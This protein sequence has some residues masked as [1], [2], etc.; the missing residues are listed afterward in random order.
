MQ[1]NNKQKKSYLKMGRE[2]EQKFFQRSR[3]N[4]QQLHEKV[5]DINNRQGNVHTSKL[6]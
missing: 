3:T 4:G 5:L 1:L 6:Q 2:T